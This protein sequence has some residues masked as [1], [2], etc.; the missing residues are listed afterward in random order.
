[1]GRYP[2]CPVPDETVSLDPPRRPPPTAVGLGEAGPPLP[3]GR[4]N[5]SPW[6]PPHGG[7]LLGLLRR[8]EVALFGVRRTIG[9]RPGPTPPF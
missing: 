1:M 7:G 6:C 5:R 2:T 3:P 9:P 8:V 4:P